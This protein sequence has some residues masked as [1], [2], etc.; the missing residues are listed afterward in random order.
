MFLIVR[1]FCVYTLL[2]AAYTPVSM[3]R[4]L[5]IQGSSTVV[6]Y[7]FEGRAD[8]YQ[9]D[10]GV[11]FKVFP[12]SSGRGVL[13]LA[14][15]EADIAMISSD[16]DLIVQRLN[17]MN[18]T[19]LDINNFVV[20]PLAQARVLFVVHPDNPITTLTRDQVKA[21][22]TG[23]IADWA[24]LGHPELGAV[25]VVSEHP[26]GAIYT[27]VLEQV[28]HHKPLAMD[29]IVLQNAPQVALVVSQV[30]GAFGMLSNATPDDQRHAVK[31]IKTSGFDVVQNLSFVM[32]RDFEATNKEAFSLITFLQERIH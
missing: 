13:S 4:D 10:S 29:S 31:V 28:T 1:I 15:G 23:Q 30:P 16:L 22:F 24:D 18:S 25:Q 26:T 5:I 8:L 17:Q 27:L 19:N 14:H 20:Y 9:K 11:A 12:S 32:R 2:C 21:L 7:V 6:N 3:A